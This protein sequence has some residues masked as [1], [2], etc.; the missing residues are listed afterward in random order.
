MEHP[1]HYLNI[2]F[3]IK[4][5]WQNVIDVHKNT[6]QRY[7]DL[8]C[9]YLED[10][11]RDF[12]HSL[13]L[14]C[15]HAYIWNWVGDKRRPENQTYHIDFPPGRS[16]VAINFLLYGSA[17]VTEWMNLDRAEEVHTTHANEKQKINYVEY[18]SGEC[19]FSASLHGDQP[20]M[21]RI[22]IPHRV[23]TDYI[24]KTRVSY[25]LRFFNAKKENLEWNEAVDILRPYFV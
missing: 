4:K 10:E 12:F 6:T 17:S 13:G 24:E 22:N 8:G 23:R 20:M 14:T 19:D 7:F 25:S 15:S 2:K 11:T 5:E 9:K 21:A 18:K 1:Y 3:C 16:Q